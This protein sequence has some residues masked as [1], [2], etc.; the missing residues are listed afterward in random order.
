MSE[1]EKNLNSNKDAIEKRIYKWKEKLIDL[2][3]RNRLLNFKF[4]F[5]SDWVPTTTEIIPLSTAEKINL[6]LDVLTELQ[7][8]SIFIFLPFVNNKN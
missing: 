3:K 4:S 5:S 2:S 7:R 6:F 1:T 8:S